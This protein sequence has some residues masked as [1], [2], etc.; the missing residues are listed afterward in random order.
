MQNIV[1]LAKDY[2]SKIIDEKLSAEYAYHNLE[3]TLEVLENVIEIGENSGLT[4]EELELVELAAIFHDTGWIENSNNHEENSVQIAKKFLK[5]CLYNPEKIEKVSE[6]ILVTNLNNDTKYL[7]QTVLRDADI[8]HIGKKGFYSRSQTLKSEIEFLETKKIEEL[9]WIECTIDFLD[10]TEFTT[11]YAIK[12]YNKRRLKNINKL[13]KR[14][15]EMLEREP[16][17]TADDSKTK[18]NN[19]NTI[20]RK[21]KNIGRGVETMFR[22]TIRT[23]VEFSSMA[24]SKANIMISVNTLILTAIVAFLAKSLDTN[25]YLIAPSAILTIVSLTTLIFAITV[26]RPKITSGTF[27]NEEIKAKKTNLLFFGNFYNM[28]FKDFEWGMNEMIKDSDYLYGSMIMDYY[29]LGQVLGEKYRK[30]RICYNL[31]MYGITISIIAFA[32]AII[33][34]PTGVQIIP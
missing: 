28:N 8:L 13:Q 24:D 32:I 29:I 16:P 3:H 4:A 33:F 23:H 5:S 31:F 1:Q 26:T 9:N 7:L 25:P 15:D 27:T 10:K 19:D 11:E 14:K 6:L 12:N 20:K 2:A 17:K 34:T 18:K 21:D 22:N 30:L